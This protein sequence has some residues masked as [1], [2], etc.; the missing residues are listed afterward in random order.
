MG[1]AAQG[2]GEVAQ[3]TG[4]LGGF[5]KNAALAAVG[6]NAAI[7]IT[8]TAM[9]TVSE[10]YEATAG[11]AAAYNKEI[12]ETS[13]NLGL[14][15]EETSRIVQAMDDYGVS[16]S[17]VTTALEMMTKR[18]VQPSIENLAQLADKF[19]SISDPVERAALMTETLGR[20]WTTLT[21]MLSQG[22]DAFRKMAAGVED[23]LIVTAEAAAAPTT[24]ITGMTY[25]EFRSEAARL[26]ASAM[27]QDDPCDTS[28]GQIKVTVDNTPWE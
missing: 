3:S 28:P 16:A 17:S 25:G 14:S 7:G 24:T 5:M 23:S 21:P 18:G 27:M 4:K 15:T 26:F 1:A 6:L 13:I 9:R 19:V 20:N 2:A 8:Q 12:R 10:V 22:G 11:K